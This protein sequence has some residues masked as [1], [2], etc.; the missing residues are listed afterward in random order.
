MT[1]KRMVMPLSSI[2][3]AVMNFQYR[4]PSFSRVMSVFLFSAANFALWPDL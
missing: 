4:S 2:S 1:C 3:V